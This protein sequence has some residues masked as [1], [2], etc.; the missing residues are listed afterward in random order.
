MGKRYRNKKKAT[1]DRA[2]PMVL[3]GSGGLIYVPPG[4]LQSTQGQVFYGGSTKNVATGQSAL[5]SPG[6]PLPQQKNVNPGGYPVQWR[7][8]VAVNTFPPDRTLS[9]PERPSFQQLR[10]LA[11]LYD[12]VTLCERTW[13]DLVPRMQLKIAL[14]QAYTE[15]GA[16]EKDYRKEISYFLDW[17]ASP[18][19]Q[20]DLHSWIRMALREQTQID[21][22]YIYK[23]KKRGGGLFSLELVAGDQMKPLLD[24]WGKIP[25]P[26][27]YAYQQ[28][29]WGI[30]G[31]WFRADELLHYQESPAADNPYGMS[32]VERV[33][34]RVNQALRKQKKDLSHFTE[35]NIPQGI[36]KVPENAQWTPDQIDAFEQA[37]NALLSGSATQQVRMRFTQP[38]MEYQAFEQYQLDPMFDKFILNVAVSAYGL[39]MQDLAFTEDIHKSSGDSQQ[40]VTYRRTIDPLARVYA[41]FLTQIMN[42]DFPPEMHGDMFE[43]SF[44]G[45]EEQEDLQSEVAA[46]SEAI[47]NATISPANAAKKLGFPDIPET[48]PLFITK[49]GIVPL[50]NFEV[51]SVARKAQDAAQL[52]GLQ[53]AGNPSNQDDDEDEEPEEETQLDDT[54]SKRQSTQEERYT[55][56]ELVQLLSQQMQAQTS[57]QEDGAYSLRSEEERVVAGTDGGATKSAEGDS[58]EQRHTGIMVAFMLDPHTS[59]QL[60]LSGGESSKDLHV[61]L[62]ILGDINEPAMG[63]LHPAQTLDTIKIGLSTFAASASPLQGYVGGIGRFTNRDQDVT[64]IVAMVNVPGLTEWRQRLVEVLES[65]GYGIAHNFD[66]LPHITLAYISSDAPMPVD[67]IPSLLLKFDT[68]CLAVGDD[69]Y[70]FPIGQA[71]DGNQKR[72]VGAEYRRWRQRAIDDVKEG[73]PQRPFTTTLIPDYLHATISDML[74][75]CS[76]I[77]GVKTVFQRARSVEAFDDWHKYEPTTAKAIAKLRARGVKAIRWNARCACE[78]CTAMNGEVRAVGDAFSN[79]SYL[80]PSHD[81]CGCDYEEVDMEFAPSNGGVTDKEGSHA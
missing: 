72:S 80:P 55:I 63:A 23:R 13:F 31:A 5:F 11:K 22:L 33:I 39:S 60:T 49:G 32:R 62:A 6:I 3:P 29:P 46:Y 78:H 27:A 75:E 35:G 64:P 28:Y 10:N 14:K 81:G 67:D 18:D 8:P 58:N 52:A 12:G 69:R 68:I 25:Q 42:N 77:E 38:G 70:F 36:M 26:P 24:A 48:G 20:H 53:L 47:Q 7:F 43:A 54:Q 1:L 34:M 44:T 66:Y 37:W 41:G 19:K 65:M 56:S 71:L 9:D 16:E 2:I 30:P 74:E 21:E 76:S 57:D 40:N 73:R 61:S 45:F 50:A 17:F 4:A 79:G 51:G 59:E 15:Q